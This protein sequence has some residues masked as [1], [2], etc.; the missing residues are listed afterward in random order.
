MS[1]RRTRFDHRLRTKA[2]GRMTRLSYRH[3]IRERTKC[4]ARGQSPC[5]LT[6]HSHAT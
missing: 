1:C 2:M 3:S 5:L 4:A 6:S